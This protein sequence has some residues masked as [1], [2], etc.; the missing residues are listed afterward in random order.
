MEMM[1]RLCQIS[2]L[3]AAGGRDD[4]AELVALLESEG[5]AESCLLAAADRL[6]KEKMGDQV[7]LRGL[8][9][10]SNYCERNCLYCGLRRSNDNL[11]RYR[12]DKAEILAVARAG[13]ALG[14]KTVVLQS[15]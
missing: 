1:E 8:I 3:A 5:E 12:M 2:E 7:H 10:F 14:Y 11:V 15:G 6:R 9:E 13:A 4:R